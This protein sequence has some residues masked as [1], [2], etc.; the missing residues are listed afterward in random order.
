MRANPT[1]K[2]LRGSIVLLLLVALEGILPAKMM[3][4][5]HS[6]DQFLETAG[7]YDIGVTAVPSTLSLGRVQFVVT[8]LDSATRQPVPDASVL[9]R[10]KH[11]LDEAGGWGLAVNT[12]GIPE[13]YDAQMNLDK[14]GVWEVN[15][16]VASSLGKVSV[17][18]PSVVIRSPRN[19]SDGTFV[20]AGIMIVLTGG[21]GYLWWS[22]RREERKRSAEY[23]T[24]DT[25]SHQLT[26]S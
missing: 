10:V 22:T 20:F 8:V 24:A 19:Y 9:L 6:P 18:I 23:S 5:G 25:Q 2:F 7:S 14:P 12:T 26:Q 11:E 4:Q 3:A 13:R 16:E 15:V 21:F 17:E 1:Q